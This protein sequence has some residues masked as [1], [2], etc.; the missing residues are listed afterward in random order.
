MTD[1]QVLTENYIN[2]WYETEDAERRKSI[3]SLW[4]PHSQYLDPT[5]SACGYESLNQTVTAVHK[6]FIKPGKY[7]F[8][9]RRNA[10][11]H[12]NIVRFNWEMADI[13]AGSTTTKYFDLLVLG[14]DG[15]IQ[16]DYRF[17]DPPVIGGELN[18]FTDRYVQ[19][20][21]EPDAGRRRALIEE[22]WAPEGSQIYDSGRPCG[23]DALFERVSI[24][25]EEF[26][27]AGEYM[28]RSTR[29]ANG[30][31]NV[32][33]FNWEMVRVNSGKVEDVG[34]EL[35]VRADDGRILFDYQFIG[36]S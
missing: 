36:P 21:Q 20:W 1:P 33:R 30:H 11:S 16:A 29:D 13:A 9:S 25:Y 27:A 3:A 18:E 12:S 23:H 4:A 14:G 24:A 32:V 17:I 35:F 15:R 10:Q 5:N 8:R 34:F 28:F 19:L 2:M 22:L 31:H 26:I 7:I 6:E